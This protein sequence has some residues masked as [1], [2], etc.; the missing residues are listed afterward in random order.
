M[1]QPASSSMAFAPEISL[2][3]GPAAFSFSGKYHTALWVRLCLNKLLRQE[4]VLT[5]VSLLVPKG[6]SE[7]LKFCVLYLAEVSP[8][9]CL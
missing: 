5:Q 7:D 3:P 2:S 9:L 8:S 1:S 4:P 6:P